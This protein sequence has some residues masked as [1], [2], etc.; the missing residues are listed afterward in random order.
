M[1]LAFHITLSNGDTFEWTFAGE[2]L[3]IGRAPEADLRLGQHTQEMV[4]WQHLEI[5]ETATGQIVFTDLESTNGTFLNGNRVSA[6]QPLV[7]GDLLALGQ[8]GPQIKVLSCQAASAVP[9]KVAPHLGQHLGQL[10]ELARQ[11]RWLLLGL[12]ALGL[13]VLF[14]LAALPPGDETAEPPPGAASDPADPATEPPA[15]PTPPPDPNGLA[16]R[17]E[18]ILRTHCHRCHGQNGS[19]EGGFNYVLNLDAMLDAGLVVSSEPADSD[20]WVRMSEAEMPPPDEERRP[21][22]AEISVIESWIRTGAE[23]FYEPVEIEFVRDE[24][25]LSI[26]RDDLLQAE[27][28]AR[29]FLRYLTLTHL[30]NAGISDDE[31]QTFRNALAKLL[32]SLSWKRNITNPTAV[33]DGKTI[34]R[35]D[36]RD[37]DWSDSV[38][39]D[40]LAAN[41]YGVTSNLA[42]AQACRTMTQSALPVVRADWFVFAASQPPLYHEV[43]QLP[44]TDRALEE[45]LKISAS[46]NIQR[47]SV[48]RAGFVRS[49]VSQHNRL[50]ERHDSPYGA[51]WKSYDFGSSNGLQSLFDRPLGPAAALPER[52]HARA[53]AHDG[54]EIIFN[55]PNGLQGY[56]LVDSEGNRIDKGPT[57]IVTDPKQPDRAV[58]NGISCMSCHYAGIIVKDDEVRANVLQHAAAFPERDVV[59]AI[60]PSADTMRAAMEEDRQRFQQAVEALGSRITAQGEPVV[61]MSLRFQ[62]ELDLP[63]AAAEAGLKP[64]QLQALIQRQSSLGRQIG[65]LLLPAGRVKRDVYQDAF[66]E[67]IHSHG[68]AIPFQAR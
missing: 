57:S 25:I 55:L 66:P 35:I 50:I 33:D 10:G 30:A 23:R 5:V 26:L 3:A 28:R 20:L 21:T 64:D 39:K 34:Y 54:G 67:I 45:M 27:A 8:T 29:P 53:F 41:P 58:V 40:V 31:L 60:Y 6:P 61:N 68:A 62:A 12:A 7:V 18:T 1:Q 16:A 32:N 52:W 2:R 17:A 49:G 59:Y 65:T 14:L 46:R 13:L 42:A 56:L 4:S 48:Q 51:Y 24:V 44:R 19:N 9:A 43:L 37:Y 22:P 11:H 15:D 38:W 63:L 47:E 36:I